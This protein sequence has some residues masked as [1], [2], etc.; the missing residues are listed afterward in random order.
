MELETGETAR[1]PADL[2]GTLADLAGYQLSSGKTFADG[3]T[4][5]ATELDRTRV[6]HRA[7]AFI[8]NMMVAA[9]EF[10]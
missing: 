10:S 6:Q 7:S 5:G 2:I 1:A 8:P 3:D 4:F 9:L